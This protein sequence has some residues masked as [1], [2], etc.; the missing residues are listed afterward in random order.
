M[1]CCAHHDRLDQKLHVDEYTGMVCGSE[2]RVLVLVPGGR[3]SEGE[4][5]VAPGEP[6]YCCFKCPTLLAAIRDDSGT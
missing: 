6:E 5:N 3:M 2:K 1:A 4:Y